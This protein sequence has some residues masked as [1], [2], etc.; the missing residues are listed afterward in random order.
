M[1]VNQVTVTFEFSL[2][3]SCII[4]RICK[5]FFV[6]RVS[7]EPTTSCTRDRDNTTQCHEDTGNREEHLNFC[8]SVI[9]KISWIHWIPFLFHLGKTQLNEFTRIDKLR[10]NSSWE[11]KICL[12]RSAGVELIVSLLE[13]T[14]KRRCKPGDPA[15]LT[16]ELGHISSEVENRGTD[17]PT[18][19]GFKTFIL[20]TEL[21]Y[22]C[23]DSNFKKLFMF[24]LYSV[25]F[26]PGV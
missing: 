26:S 3:Q 8:A 9:S 17:G 5:I 16:L 11:L 23:T 14:P 2:I 4:Y 19:C 21:Y 6:K 18:K 15:R 24:L 1:N 7:L 25:I 13:N 22:I 10:M 12:K 20:L